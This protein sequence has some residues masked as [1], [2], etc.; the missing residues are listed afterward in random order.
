MAAPREPIAVIA[1]IA[2]VFQGVFSPALLQLALASLT[3]AQAAQLPTMTAEMEA[4]FAQHSTPA[5]AAAAEAATA[6]NAAAVAAAAATARAIGAA[7]AENARDCAVP[8]AT[9]PRA[10]GTPPPAWPVSFD[11]DA[12]CSGP[13]AAVDALLTQYG[14]PLSRTVLAR[15]TRLA[16][17]IGLRRL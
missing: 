15:R 3:Q 5:V 14:L 6:A 2:T 9:V 12:L 1:A 10:D 13:I 16:L 7:R 17:H 8:Y 4:L 11:R